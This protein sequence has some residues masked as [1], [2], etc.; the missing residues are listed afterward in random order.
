MSAARRRRRRLAVRRDCRVGRVGQIGGAGRVRRRVRRELPPTCD[1]RCAPLHRGVSLS[2]THTP[3]PLLPRGRQNLDS[4]NLQAMPDAAAVP[5]EADR[6]VS[7]CDRRAV[8]ETRRWRAATSRRR[9]RRR[10]RAAKPLFCDGVRRNR[11]AACRPELRA[12]FPPDTATSPRPAARS[13]TLTTS[14]LFLSPRT[15]PSQTAAAAARAS[16]AASSPTRCRRSS[17]GRRQVQRQMV[18]GLGGELTEEE[19]DVVPADLR[20]ETGQLVRQG[21]L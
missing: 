19:L 13:L 15:T 10:R 6:G 17:H 20:S 21:K 2:P 18:C 16:A 4:R 7:D 5:G 14:Q 11:C 9:R 3:V 12:Q 1:L 8:A